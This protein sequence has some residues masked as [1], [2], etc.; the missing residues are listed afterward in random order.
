MEYRNEYLVRQ[1][2]IRFSGLG[3]FRS[4]RLWLGRTVIDREIHLAGIVD[5]RNRFIAGTGRGGPYIEVGCD[6][7]LQRLN[8]QL[9]FTQL[10]LESLRANRPQR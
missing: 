8:E 2:F 6:V 9:V 4:I 3:F 10:D 5:G 7:F 1:A